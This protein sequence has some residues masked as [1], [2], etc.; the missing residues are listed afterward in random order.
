MGG[1]VGSPAGGRRGSASP[2]ALSDSSLFPTTKN[3]PLRAERIR[4]KSD[5]P[6]TDGQLRAKRE[7]FWDTAPAFEG[8][9]EIW[10]ALKAAVEAAT[11]EDQAL[12]QAILDGAGISLPAG[13]ATLSGH[14]SLNEAKKN[15]GSFEAFVLDNI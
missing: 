5:I 2:S 9:S 1:C 4:W 7:E 14:L 11:K 3:K 8:K 10:E 12:A 15:P 13:Q 6:L